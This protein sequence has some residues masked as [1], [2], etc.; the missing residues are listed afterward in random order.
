MLG[1]K[2]PPTGI[3]PRSSRFYAGVM[4][5]RPLN[6]PVAGT[7]SPSM[8]CSFRRRDHSGTP[9]PSQL[10][11]SRWKTYLFATLH[12]LENILH[13]GMTFSHICSDSRRTLPSILQHPPP[14]PH[15]FP[16]HRPQNRNKSSPPMPGPPPRIPAAPNPAT[17]GP[18][19][20]LQR[21]L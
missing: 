16:S 4:T 19:V 5:A 1:D 18:H 10:C 21:A 15:E 8:D 17:P 14:C 12:S 3:E 13:L 2:L 11:T 20:P 9:T 7:N 6:D